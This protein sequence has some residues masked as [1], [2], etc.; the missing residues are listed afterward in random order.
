MKYKYDPSYYPSVPA[1]EIWL[2]VPEQAMSVG[3]L[4]AIID[5]G[6]DGTLVPV[7]IVRRLPS[8]LALDRKTLRSQWGEPRVV[9]ACWVD[10]GIAHIRLPAIEIVADTLGDEVILGRNVLNRLKIFLDGPQAMLDVTG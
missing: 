8:M 4:S 2:A 3:P 9:R 10:L 7:Q 1:V 5:T 6:A